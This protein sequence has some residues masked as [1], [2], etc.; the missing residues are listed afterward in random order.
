MPASDLAVL[1]GLFLSAL[2]AATIVP[3]QSETALAAILLADRMP[4]W[5]P[6]AVA[7]TGNTLG[8]VINW[9][10]GRMIGRLRSKRWFPASQQQLERAEA[11]F[12]R[13]GVWSLLLSWVPFVGDPLTV[14]AGT[15]RVKLAV[16]VAIVAVAKTGRYVVL[17]LALGQ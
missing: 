8:A 15:L 9:W 16:F 2:L 4:V 12:S 11:W 1:L 7:S 17:A 14:V 13:Y 5:L 10:L 3:A 6:V